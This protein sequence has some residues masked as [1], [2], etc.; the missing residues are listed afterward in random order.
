MNSAV[1]ADGNG[2]T[3]IRF[4]SA[5][6]AQWANASYS[7]YDHSWYGNGTERMRIDSGGSVLI[8]AG[9]TSGTPTSDYRSLEIGRQGNTITGAPWK[10]NLYLTCNATITGGSTAFTYRY[11][12]E[13]P[14][15]MDLEDG[16]VRFYNAAAGTAGNTISWSER[17]RIESSGQ[18]G[19]GTNAPDG[20]LHI[21]KNAT[22]GD[23]RIGGGNGS[24][25]S[26]IFIQSNGDN[27]YIDNY[28]DNAYKHLYIQANRLLL[29]TAANTGNVGIG[30]TNPQADLDVD[31]DL[32]VNR[33]H[34]NVFSYY[35]TA[36]VT[37][38]YFHIKTGVGTNQVCMHMY[39]VEGYA[40]G[41]NAIIDE[42][43]GFHTD[44]GGSIYG[45]SY[46][47]TYANNIY[48][49][50]DNKVVLVFGTMTTYYASFMVHLIESGMYTE[51]FVKPSAATYSSSNSGAY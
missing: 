2:S 20:D 24:G 43:F 13:A 36:S 15:R 48:A 44:S 17:M 37:N 16:I 38:Q 29:N 9:A 45:K 5:T 4:V 25:N 6:N 33:Y 18:V 49:S 46:K 11:A 30:V 23:I 8:G 35:T 1:T 26:R 40:Y 39:H 3:N 34:K 42:R 7:A 32:R 28:G 19:I 10:S 31:Q 14:V 41:Q 47:G 27:S 21:Y 50:S 51:L 22:Q 12:S